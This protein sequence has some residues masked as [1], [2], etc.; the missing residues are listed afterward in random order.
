MCAKCARTSPVDVCARKLT[1]RLERER[2]RDRERER[3]MERERAR[4]REEPTRTG[5]ETKTRAQT[6]AGHAAVRLLP[7][8]IELK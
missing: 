7:N 8:S 3:E 5:G 1:H 4:E 6:K 2:E